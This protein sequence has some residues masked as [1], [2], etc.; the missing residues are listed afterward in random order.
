MPAA[1]SLACGIRQSGCVFLC[2]GI[3]CKSWVIIGLC[4][5][6]PSLWLRVPRVLWRARFMHSGKLHTFRFARC[7]KC[8]AREAQSRDLTSAKARCAVMSPRLSLPATLLCAVRQ[9]CIAQDMPRCLSTCAHAMIRNRLTS[10]VCLAEEEEESAGP[11]TSRALQASGRAS[12][13]VW[14]AQGQPILARSYSWHGTRTARACANVARCFFIARARHQ[15]KATVGLRIQAREWLRG[16]TQCW[17]SHPG[18][19]SEFNRGALC[20]PSWCAEFCPAGRSTS[21]TSSPLAH[22]PAGR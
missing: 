22:N 20:Q 7:A 1:A 21:T 2:R 13:V 6:M 15:G 8:V 16:A 14:L 19:A 11:T 3:R 17:V 4:W 18:R 10:E 9:A 5:G 12:G